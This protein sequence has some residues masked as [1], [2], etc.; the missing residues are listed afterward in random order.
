MKSDMA[1][2]G[3]KKQGQETAI[4]LGGPKK[5]PWPLVAIKRYGI[6][7]HALKLARTPVG[8]PVGRR[9]RRI[10]SETAGKAA[11]DRFRPGEGEAEL[12]Q[13]TDENFRKLNYPPRAEISLHFFHKLE[14]G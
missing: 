11:R 7:V 12:P 5:R 3:G 6:C 2:V 1:A 9:E 8:V 10:V 4:R 13:N 14:K